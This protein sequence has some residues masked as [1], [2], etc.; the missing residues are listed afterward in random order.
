MRIADGHYMFNL[1][2]KGLKTGVPF[3]ILIRDSAL[4]TQNIADRGD[5]N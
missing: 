4:G 3:T 2:T 5:R 1:A